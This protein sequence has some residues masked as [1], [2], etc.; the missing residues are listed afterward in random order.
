MSFLKTKR[1]KLN[2]TVCLV[3]LSL[4]VVGCSGPTYQ[5]WSGFTSSD[6]TLYFGGIDGKVYAINPT[7]RSQNATFPGEN[8]W[9]FD[10]PSVG[11]PG[12]V[13]GPA[14]APASPR[15]SI[16]ATPAVVGDL[17]CVGTYAGGNGK[18]I[19][20]NRLSPGYT[21]GVPLLSKGEWTYPSGVKSIGA[22]VGSPVV[23][24]KT[25]YVGS[26]DGKLYAIDAAYGEKKWEFDTG[27]K[28]WASPA[29]EDGVVYISNYDR[30]LF[31][32][33]S[34]DGSQ[35]WQIELPASIASSPAISGDDIF[36]GTFDNQLYSIDRT[37]GKVKW[38][39]KGGNWFWSTPVVKDGVVYAGCLDHKV[40]ALKVS[41][42]EELW[43]PFTVDDQII[44]T[45][46]LVGNLLILASESGTIYMLNADNG[47]PERDSVPVDASVTVPVKAPLYAEGNMVYIHAGNFCV[48]SIDVQS[49]KT[50]QVFNYSSNQ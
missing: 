8:E 6:G 26:S 30:K 10:V 4:F 21:E 5:G 25:L 1:Q 23:V 38:N 14:C 43:P 22:I 3:I 29:V 49:G 16:Y 7:A 37:D 47:K 11:V 32:I 42:G 36:L 28:I 45:P 46:V 19:A 20:I 40:Y 34:A 27:G 24:D 41:T 17:L 15:A 12:T 44:A 35:I 13:C 9:V 48:Y 50:V 31:A 2:L 33:S 39:F 18:L